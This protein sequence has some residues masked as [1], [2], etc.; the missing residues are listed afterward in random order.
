MMDYGYAPGLSEGSQV[1]P[2]AVTCVSM[3]ESRRVARAI[4]FRPFASA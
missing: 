3:S 2:S 1:A 4:R